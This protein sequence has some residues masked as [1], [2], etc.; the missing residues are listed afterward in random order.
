M[1]P[2][3]KSYES[4]GPSPNVKLG[5]VNRPGNEPA[6]NQFYVRLMTDG[7][8]VPAW[9]KDG[10][11]NKVAKRLGEAQKWVYIASEGGRRTRTCI[12]SLT[13]G[14]DHTLT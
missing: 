8:A 12:L 2:P 7:R 1:K 14:V 3:I 13:A 10:S 5:T 4:G 11:F 9:K 6:R